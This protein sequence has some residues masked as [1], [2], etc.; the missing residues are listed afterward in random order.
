M[1]MILS[2]NSSPRNHSGNE[3]T[4]EER[5][6]D[7]AETDLI[8]QCPQECFDRFSRLASKI[9]RVPVALL[10]FVEADR[11]YFISQNGLSEPYATQRQTPLSHSFCQYVVR[12]GQSLIISDA[13]QNPLVKDNLAIPDLGVVAYLGIPILSERHNVLGSFCAIDGKSRI[14]SE[15]EVSIL[16]DL[17]V[18]VS[19]EIHLRSAK[20]RLEVS[21]L[22]L[23]RA[24]KNQNNLVHMIV[25]DLRAPLSSFLGGMEMVQM[26]GPL[27][28]EQ[29][30]FLKL[31]QRG[32]QG[33]LEMI[34]DLLDV[35]TIE[36]G[37]LELNL[38]SFDSE[39]IAVA[40]LSQVRDAATERKQSLLLK[41]APQLPAVK[42]DSVMIKRVC[43]NLLSH[44]IKNTPTE[45]EIIFS[46]DFTADRLWVLFCFGAKGY[47][48]PS[49]QLEH[50]FE[51]FG[52]GEEE[53]HHKRPST[54]LRLT[55]SQMIVQAHGS[56]IEVVNEEALGS[57]FRFS[58]TTCGV[59]P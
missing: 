9:L 12:S 2:P 10:S 55:Y 19:A 1:S 7:L 31:A 23:R 14:W 32:G 54:G 51:K 59:T 17:A 42:G 27:N 56:K 49:G 11:Q 15:E 16:K 44:L 8:N 41:A 26:A 37:K 57:T 47:S 40:A 22:N 5:L 46:L 4:D 28:Q 18:A 20:K 52:Q 13:R 43:T 24:E 3:L 53:L 36:S 45:G 58:L 25:H 6:K 38:A 39:E 34:H 50:I 29:Q 48:I 33:L 30:D 21:N 35:H